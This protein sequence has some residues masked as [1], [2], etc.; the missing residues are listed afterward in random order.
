MSDR[1]GEK[2]HLVRSVQVPLSVPME[3]YDRLQEEFA[4]SEFKEQTSIAETTET[5]NLFCEWLVQEKLVND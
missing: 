5:N 2:K 4:E 3:T 1:P